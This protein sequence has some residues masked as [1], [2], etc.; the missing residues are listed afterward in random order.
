[1]FNFLKYLSYA[2]VL[3]GAVNWGLIGVFNFDLVAYIFG[4]MTYLSRLVYS[5][6]GLSAIVSVITVYMSCPCKK[7]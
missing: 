6:V 4:E 3:I 5:L 1:M 7:D 2:L